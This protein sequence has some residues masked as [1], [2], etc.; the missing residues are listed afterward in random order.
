MLI[1][2]E[3]VYLAEE[4]MLPLDFRSSSRHQIYSTSRTA[5]AV[6]RTQTLSVWPAGQAECLQ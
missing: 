4:V 2:L 6:G 5:P 3:G 1:F